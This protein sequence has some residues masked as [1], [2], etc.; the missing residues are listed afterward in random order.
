MRGLRL[1][2]AFR[3]GVGALSNAELA[4]RTGLPRPTVSRL[5]R[6][7][8]DAG[9]LSYDMATRGYRLAAVFMS[10]ANAFRYEIPAVD[11]ALPFMKGV[12][13][14]EK[15]NVGLAI[16]QQ[17]EMLYLESLRESRRG[18]FRRAGPGSL[19]PMDLTSSGRAHLTGIPPEERALLM[20]QFAAVRGDQWSV[21]QREICAAQDDIERKQYCTAH[22]QPGLTVIATPLLAPDQQLYSI[23]I[24]FHELDGNTT[25][26]VERY[27]PKLLALR[28]NIKIAWE[29][30]ARSS[31]A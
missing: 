13:E 5:T 11:A 17:N 7:L 4:S 8:V 22:W 12:A 26:D 16:G 24:G 10:L 9:F 3:P 25:N 21:I 18:V 23:S 19:F 1:L 27:A 14:G 20:A 31:V 30:L 28:E 2:R 6:S 15:I 29:Q